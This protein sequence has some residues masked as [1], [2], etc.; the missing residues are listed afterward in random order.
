MKKMKFLVSQLYMLA[1]MAL[2]FISSSCSDDDDDPKVEITSLGIEDGATVNV[3]QIIQLEAQINN[4]NTQGEIEYNWEVNGENVSNV[5][6]YTFMANEKGTYTITLNITNNNDNFQKSI[7][8]NAQMYPSSFYVVNEGKYGTPG[9]VN[10]YQKG[11]WNYKIISKLGNTSTVGVVNGN[12]IYIVSKDSPFLVKAKLSDYS[13]V[14]KIEDGLGDNGQGNNFCI[15]N[16]QTGIL[17]TTNGAFKVNLN[18]LTLGEKL[19]D[20][21]NVR[22]DKEDIYK[23]ENYLFI[24]SQETVKVY[25]INDLSFNKQIGTEIKT[26]FALTKDGMLWTANENKLIGI[27][28]TTLNSKDIELPDDMKIYYNQW[29]YTPTGLCASI[30]ENVLYFANTTQEGSS[31][32]GKH[33][34][35]FNIRTKSATPLFS[36]PAENMSIYGAGIQVDPKNGDVYLIYKQDGWGNESCNTN[37]YVVD[38]IT[39]TQK[40]IIDYTGEY[41]FPSTITFQ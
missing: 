16:D 19:N 13:I 10:R 22:N 5:S 18:P 35:K 29:S 39:G 34:Y 2:P 32:Y 28:T 27:D 24:R 37:I 9:S 6:N 1:L 41:W 15:I 26:G 17:T 33:I 11:E 21:D 3:G 20:M 23:T 7:S 30:T 31:I 4:T 40:A 8:I 12:Y 36:T 14:D 25:N 38:G